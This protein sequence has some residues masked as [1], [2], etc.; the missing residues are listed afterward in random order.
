MTTFTK[1]N[2]NSTSFGNVSASVY[3]LSTSTSI[4]SVLFSRLL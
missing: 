1:R 4:Y 2:M 3:E